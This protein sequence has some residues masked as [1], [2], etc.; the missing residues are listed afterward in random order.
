MR[1]LIILTMGFVTGHYKSNVYVHTR[2]KK[3]QQKTVKD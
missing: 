1:V 2:G 3:P